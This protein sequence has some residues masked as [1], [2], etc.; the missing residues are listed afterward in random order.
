MSPRKKRYLW[1]GALYL[2]S[3]IAYA[4]VVCTE[5]GMLHLLR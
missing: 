3:L 5:R 2:L 4:M 1:F